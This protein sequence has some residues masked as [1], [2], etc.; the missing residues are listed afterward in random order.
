MCSHVFAC[1]RVRACVRAC[2]TRYKT[3]EILDKGHEW[4]L[5]EV[6]ESGLRGRGGAGFPSGLKWSFMN[7]PGDGRPKYVNVSHVVS[8]AKSIR[9]LVWL[10]IS[11][12][13]RACTPGLATTRSLDPSHL[14]AHPLAHL[15]TTLDPNRPSQPPFRSLAARACV[16]LLA[17]AHTHTHT[18]PVASICRPPTNKPTTRCSSIIHSPL[19]ALEF[20]TLQISRDQRR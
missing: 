19:H 16:A 3:K 18:W 13:A 12:F 15:C 5:K 6:K 20:T 8:F 1:K 10:R 17:R 14:Q 11:V 2:S 7:K 4:I 9:T